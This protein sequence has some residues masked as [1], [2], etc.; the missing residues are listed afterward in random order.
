MGQVVQNDLSATEC[1]AW[2]GQ[3][4]LTAKPLVVP[5]HNLNF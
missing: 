3:M 2:T 1:R 5:Y 4:Y